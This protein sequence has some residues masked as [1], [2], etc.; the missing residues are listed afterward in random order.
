MTIEVGTPEAA[1]VVDGLG[2]RRQRRHR[3]LLPSVHGE[4]TTANSY[5]VSRVW[6]H[7][8]MTMRPAVPA[9]TAA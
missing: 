7:R 8:R 2:L 4:G 6:S 5:V 1:Q 9:A 3:T